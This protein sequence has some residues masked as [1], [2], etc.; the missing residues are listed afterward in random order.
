M[1]SLP[2]QQT[3]LENHEEQDCLQ[4]MQLYSV[5]SLPFALK[6]TIDLG[7]LEII[8]KASTPSCMLSP[9]E[10]A[11]QL[12][13][14]NPD[15][16]SIIDRLLRL[17]ASHSIVRC[18][19]VTGE[20]G[21]SHRSY[22]LT[23]VGKYFLQNEGGISFAPLLTIYLEKYFIE[24]WKY[25][26]DVTLEGGFS[27]VKAYGMHWFELLGKDSE[28]SSTFN[29]AMSVYTTLVMNKILETY[30]GF[31]GVN[32]VVDVGGGFGTN[33]NLII[34]KYPHIKG[35]NFDLPQVIK[36]APNFPGVEHVAGDMFTELP[37]AEVIFMKT[38]LHDW[39]DDRCLKLLK[40]CY[41][42]LPESGKVVIVE[43]MVLDLPETDILTQTVLQRDLALFHILPGAR[44]RTKQEFENLAKAAGFTTLKLVSR[45]YN[46]W[47]M[48]LH[49]N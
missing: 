12:S 18:N 6:A 43:S 36:D 24:C 35:I 26:K 2:N 15:A 32:Q 38:I 16:P 9:A 25:M 30:E 3:I 28:M 8:A 49:K 45:A 10:I 48:E 23:S 47:V 40:A 19:L 39:G 33:L 20:D 41:D 14:N 27:C 17:L 22:G 13:N 37:R 1:D 46:F 42:S 4:A 11:S 31:E 29:K 5:T 21:G 34:S 44:E 7:L